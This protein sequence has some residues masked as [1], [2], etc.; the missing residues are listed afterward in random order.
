MLFTG[1]SW[2][3]KIH[4]VNVRF[5]FFM[6][7]LYYAPVILRGT[8]F[9]HVWA[10]V[11]ARTDRSFTLS[12]PRSQQNILIGAIFQDALWDLSVVVVEACCFGKLIAIES[13][14]ASRFLLQNGL[15]F[16]DQ[17]GR[18]IGKRWGPW[19]NP[20]SPKGLGIFTYT[21]GLLHTQGF[22]EYGCT[23]RH[24]QFPGWSCLF[25]GRVLSRA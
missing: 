22:R 12:P 7:C 13:P 11:S 18:L 2:Y 15:Q 8:T 21:V 20:S 16:W 19:F 3:L 24:K 14:N 5:P 9:Q 1:T 10:L 17:R 23:D 25:Q 4:E 6:A